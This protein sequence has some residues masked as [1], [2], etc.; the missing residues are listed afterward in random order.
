MTK[1]TI[2]VVDDSSTIRNIIE[3]ELTGAGYEVLTAVNGM[4]AISMLAWMEKK[5]DLITLDIDMPRMNGFEACAK[6]REE[7]HKKRHTK[8]SHEQIPVIFVSSN[9][10]LE[11]RRTGFQLEVLDFITKPFASGDISQVVANILRPTDQFSGQQIL[12]VDDSSATRRIINKLLQ[13]LGVEVFE[14]KNG[15]EALAVVE[16]SSYDFDLIITDYMMPEM[17]GD[18]FCRL[19][20]HQRHMHQ[21]PVLIVSGL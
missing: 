6:I 2:L 1:Q 14:A 9:D 17:R 11:Y 10:S 8:E 13:R 12:V 16:Q 21:V 18:E 3:R 5:P 4:E 7:Y 15:V 19:L 20:R